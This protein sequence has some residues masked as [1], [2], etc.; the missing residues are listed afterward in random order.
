MEIQR[1]NLK[2][3]RINNL[4]HFSIK[5]IKIKTQ[6]RHGLK[7]QLNNQMLTINKIRRKI[8]ISMQIKITVKPTITILIQIK[9]LWKIK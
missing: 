9:T 8:I 6:S 4:N 1:D 3:P 7:E 5:P 2:L